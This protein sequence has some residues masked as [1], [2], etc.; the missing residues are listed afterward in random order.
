MGS[1]GHAVMKEP[2]RRDEQLWYYLHK[3]RQVG[4]YSLDEL[5]FLRAKEVISSATLVWSQDKD[6]WQALG[7][8]PHQP[9]ERRPLR[10]RNWMIA[11]LG[12]AIFAGATSIVAEVPTLGEPLNHVVQLL[13]TQ[14]LSREVL[15]QANVRTTEI[16]LSYAAMDQTE[17]CRNVSPINGCFVSHPVH[18]TLPSPAPE[19]PPLPAAVRLAIEYWRSTGPAN[20]APLYEVQRS[21]PGATSSVVKARK[22]R[23]TRKASVD[24]NPDT[25]I[26]RK[27]AFSRVDQAKS[28]PTAPR[29]SNVKTASRC[30]AVDRCR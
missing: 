13:D 28:K 12:I 29:T 11:A 6:G 2:I 23:Q 15:G 7:K 5:H 26:E 27:P 16:A 1:R 8:I 10:S 19:T 24:V 20:H 4:P 30:R 22:T 25:T 3:S 21:K 14:R 17:D 9:D 18:L